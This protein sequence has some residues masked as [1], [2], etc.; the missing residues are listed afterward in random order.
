[1]TCPRGYGPAPITAASSA[2]I[3]IGFKQADI[4]FAFCQLVG[5]GES[6]DAGTDYSDSHG[7]FLWGSVFRS[8]RKLFLE[9][10]AIWD[11]I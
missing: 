4:L 1:M 6:G 11:K 2:E 8:R 3:V 9:K 5:G 10:P 7:V